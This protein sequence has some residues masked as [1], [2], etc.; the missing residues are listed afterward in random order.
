MKARELLEEARRE[1]QEE[2]KSGMKAR[3]KELL[4]EIRLAEKTLA[5]M[6]RQLDDL[7]DADVEDED[8]LVDD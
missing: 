7:M 5:E 1:I 6:R 4:R 8:A 2:A 3:I